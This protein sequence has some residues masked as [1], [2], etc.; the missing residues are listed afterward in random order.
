V[1]LI[2]HMREVAGLTQEELAVIVGYGRSTVQRREAEPLPEPDFMADCIARTGTDA[3][4]IAEEYGEKAK[5]H[6]LALVRQRISP[7]H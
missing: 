2:K 5:Q 4:Y 6:V 7:L 1:S 3:E